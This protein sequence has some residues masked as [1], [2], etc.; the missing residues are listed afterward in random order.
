MPHGWLVPGLPERGQDPVDPIGQS[1]FDAADRFV[2]IMRQLVAVTTLPQLPQGVLEKGQRSRLAAQ[3]SDDAL[4]QPRLQRQPHQCCRLAGH[5]TKPLLAEVRDH[6]LV[7]RHTRAEG[8]QLAQTAVE[9]GPKRYHDTGRTAPMRHVEEVR[10]ERSA[11]LLI[12]AQRKQL[13]RLMNLT[14]VRI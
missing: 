11:R 14:E 5:L 12:A 3:V 10:G 8:P 13:A 2:G 7:A 1:A 9:V 6:V 4:D